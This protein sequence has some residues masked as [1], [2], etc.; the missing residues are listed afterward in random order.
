MQY[1]FGYCDGAYENMEKNRYYYNGEQ[2]Y[3]ASEA[4][5]WN[6]DAFVVLE[7]TE[8]DKKITDYEKYTPVGFNYDNQ[9]KLYDNL[10]GTAKICFIHNNRMFYIV[11]NGY[12]I[13]LNGAICFR[14][15]YG[16]FVNMFNS[17]LDSDICNR[18]SEQDILNIISVIDGIPSISSDE[19]R[20]AR[21]NKEE[22]TEFNFLT[23]SAKEKFINEL[24]I[25]GNFKFSDDL[26]IKDKIS[27]RDSY[28]S[29]IMELF[30]MYKIGSLGIYIE[31]LIE[32]WAERCNLSVA[33]FL[34]DAYQPKMGEV[35][36][37][38][39]DSNVSG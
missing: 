28:E 5:D 15:P 23:D 20:K 3:A 13:S 14:S 22:I 37:L 16:E 30:D 39:R 8:N 10:E 27:D 36:K 9:F 11:K 17:D 38:K 25:Y 18:F 7:N 19:Y 12:K 26:S 2:V 32:E 35:K 6:R 31:K 21:I 1:R 4:F 33:D 29:Y 24:W 34:G